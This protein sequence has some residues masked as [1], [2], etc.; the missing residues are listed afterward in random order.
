MESLKVLKAGH[1]LSQ[2]NFQESSLLPSIRASTSANMPTFQPTLPKNS[3][4]KKQKQWFLPKK[5]FN[6]P[7][8]SVPKTQG[9]F[10]EKT[11]PQNPPK[12][13]S[14]CR[15]WGE[16]KNMV[17]GPQPTKSTTLQAVDNGTWINSSLTAL[18]Q[19]F[20]V[21][22]SMLEISKGGVFNG[23]GHWEPL[24]LFFLWGSHDLN[25]LQQRKM[26]QIVNV[27]LKKGPLFW[28]LFD[29]YDICSYQFLW[30][31]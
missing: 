2:C 11:H 15:P 22:F 5:K 17:F 14:F 26:P 23:G 10:E 18:Q 24:V 19:V 9:K 16:T 6:L 28:N 7:P 25:Q 8:A 31:A 12:N 30:D 29:I 27:S 20:R 21:K 13:V 1:W 3:E 4:K